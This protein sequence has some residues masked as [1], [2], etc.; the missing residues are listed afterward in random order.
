MSAGSIIKRVLIWSGLDVRLVRNIRI[1]Q[2]KSWEDEWKESWRFLYNYDIK[3]IVDIGANTGQ[4][5]NM[6]HKVCPDARIYS[7]EPLH[8]C[9]EALEKVFATNLRGR[10]YN[11]ALGNESSV[12]EMNQSDFSPSSSLLEM[13]DLHKRDWPQSAANTKRKIKIERLD[14]VAV[15]ME[16]VPDLLIKIDVQGYED[17]VIQGGIQTISKAKLVVAEINFEELYTGQPFFN[18]IYCM[19]R[20]LG[21]CFKGV[22][23]QYLSKVD[24]RILFADAVFEKI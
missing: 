1:A 5:A 8:E 23:D 4:F 22:V 3:T 15:T 7:F 19:M 13:E 14:D 12:I 24:G 18:D 10:A 16:I 2:K 20:E 21:F 6:I 17:K 11:F 9:F